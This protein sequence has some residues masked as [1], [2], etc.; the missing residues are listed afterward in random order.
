MLMLAL[1][2]A[3]EALIASGVAQRVLAGG[4]GALGGLVL[5]TGGILAGFTRSRWPRR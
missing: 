5:L 2:T 4:L 1:A 3:P